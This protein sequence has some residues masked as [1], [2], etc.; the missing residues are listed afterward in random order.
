[1]IRFAHEFEVEMESY[2]HQKNL[3]HYRRLIA[4]SERD[5]SR[6]EVQH[7]WLL[8]LLAD[9]EAVEIKPLHKRH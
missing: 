4:E 6:N 3:A 9:A 2:I 8:K 5:P 7:R 1:M